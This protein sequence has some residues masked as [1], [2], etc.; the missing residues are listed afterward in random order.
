MGIEENKDVVRGLVAECINPYRPDLLEHFVGEDIRVHPGTPGS[1]RTRPLCAYPKQ[2]RYT[3]PAAL[4]M[5]RTSVANG[6]TIDQRRIAVTTGIDRYCAE[7]RA[8]RY[9]PLLRQRFR[10]Y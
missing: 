2:A 7:A 4:R 3:A 9:A 6:R 10:V 1:G 5:R 8:F